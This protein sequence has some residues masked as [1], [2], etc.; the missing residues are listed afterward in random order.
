[1]AQYVPGERVFP[2]K[3]LEC[4]RKHRL[5]PH[6]EASIRLH[7]PRIQKDFSLGL[8]V[9]PSVTPWLCSHCSYK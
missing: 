7:I 5:F 2:E 3:V 9:R 1:M 6:A 8:Q 4:V